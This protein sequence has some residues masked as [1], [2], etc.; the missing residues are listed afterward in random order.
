MDVKSTKK[1]AQKTSSY[2]FSQKFNNWLTYEPPPT[3]PL[4]FDFN[5]LKYELR[6]GDVLLI[7]GRSIIS[8]AIRVVTQSPW[9][10]A[11]LYIG[12]L[13]DIEDPHLRKLVAIKLKKRE[14]VR[15]IIEGMLG[16]GNIVSPLTTY[17]ENHIR[18]CRPI[19]LSPVDSELVI[20]YAIKS[21]G[22]PYNVR[23]FLDLAR[24]ILPWSLLPRRWGSILFR[25]RT[26]EIEA[27][28][29]SSMIAE[30]FNAVQFPIL[31]HI[32]T[33]EKTGFELVQ[34]N[35]HLY[36]P[37]D[38]D[39]SPYFEIIKYPIFDPNEPLPYYRR[40]PW[41]KKGALHHD[42]GVYTEP[43]QAEANLRKKFLD[44]LL[45]THDEDHH[46]KNKKMKDPDD[47]ISK[48][49]TD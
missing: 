36:T 43:T 13:H 24:F 9:S 18:I 15:L 23:H 19:G 11:A 27:G 38:F 1:D 32:K 20:A 29:C 21:L 25:T 30:A 12:R 41:A 3:E 8:K 7:E 6:P 48:P 46:K 10:H 35:P 5:R 47:N 17:R 40:L 4:P 39:Y 14:N 31:P 28:I 37:K 42:H 49:E 22:V 2:T 45:S 16:Q 26:G 44:D 33:D 34:R